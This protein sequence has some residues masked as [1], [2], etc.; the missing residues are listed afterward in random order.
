MTDIVKKEILENLNTYRFYVLTG[1]IFS[2]ILI[3][4]IVSYG[5]YHLRVENYNILRPEPKE[6]DKIIFPPE[7]LSIYARGLDANAGRLYQLSFRGIQVQ[8][9]QQSINRVSSLFSLPDM[10]F[11]IKVI[12]ALI[13]LLFSFDAVCG[14]KEQGTLKL[15]LAGRI[16]RV[17]VVLGKLAGRY[18]LV[19][20]PFCVLFL[21]SSAV[22]SLL[23]DVRAGVEYWTRLAII[24]A[25][26][27]LYVTCFVALGTL[28]SSLVHRSSTS[29]MVCLAAWVLLVFVVPNMGATVAQAIGDVPPADRVEMQ[30]RLA[31]IQ[32]V[33]E[34]QQQM[35]NAQEKDYS[36]IM[37]QI[38]ESNNHLFQTYRPE[39]NRLIDLTRTVVRCSPSGAFGFLVTEMANTGIDRDI[40]IKDAIWMF[41]ERNFKR[42]GGLEKGEAEQFQF[43]PSST[44][45]QIAGVALPDALL[46]LIMPAVLVALAVGSFMRY[47]P[48]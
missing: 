20:V 34:T 27:A 18:L 30:Q 32:S 46:L 7:P 23:P 39:L 36:R 3:S 40:R 42:F 33:F 2:M 44:G 47:D 24:L 9:S 22:V 45:E 4:I 35:K 31:T 38:R 1:L 13:A 29:M 11:V 6:T 8:P 14:E 12:L 5:D 17:S 15:I 48:R 28:I 41:I 26:S 25:G 37:F 10:L 43:R 16:R 19:F 21:I